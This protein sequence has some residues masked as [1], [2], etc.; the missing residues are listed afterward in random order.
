MDMWATFLVESSL[1]RDEFPS[2]R[3]SREAPPCRE[4]HTQSYCRIASCVYEGGGERRGLATLREPGLE[5]DMFNIKVI[6]SAFTS[7]SPISPE[8]F[9][10]NSMNCPEG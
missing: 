2:K 8:L 6:L 7:H 4:T 10:S 3:D 9:S 5:G 1:I